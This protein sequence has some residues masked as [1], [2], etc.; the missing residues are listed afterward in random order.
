MLL[1]CQEE[2]TR[3]TTYYGCAVTLKSAAT[4]SSYVSA[5]KHYKILHVSITSGSLN[6]NTTLQQKSWWKVD[7]AVN[8]GKATN[9]EKKNNIEKGLINLIFQPYNH[10]AADLISSRIYIPIIFSQTSVRLLL[11]LKGQLHP[12]RSYFTAPNDSDYRLK[13][14]AQIR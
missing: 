12:Y 5:L 1:N 6:L 3:R 10:F 13:L 14:S 7:T 11:L 8:L 9:F 4:T 2:P